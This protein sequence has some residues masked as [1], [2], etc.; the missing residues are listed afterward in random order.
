MLTVSVVI[1]C[2]NEEKTIYP[3]LESISQQTFPINDLEVIIADGLS[4]DG[5]RAEINRFSAVHPNLAVRIV[6]NT[7]K[8]IPSGLNIGIQAAKGEFIVR[9]D[10][11]SVPASDYIEKCVTLLKQGI[12]DNVG[13]VWLI[14]PGK[15]DWI[16]RSIAVAASHPIGVGDAGYR[17]S[18]KA[19]YVD[20]V[21]FGSYR[22]EFIVSL[23]AYN[24]TLLTNEDYELN[25][26]ILKAGGR[27]YLDPKIQ[28]VYFSRPTFSALAKQ[29]WRYGYWKA[30]MVRKYPGTVRW[31]QALPPLYL[32][33]LLGLLILSFV[34]S[35]FFWILF[36]V[37]VLYSSILMIA[38]LKIALS[39]QDGAFIMGVPLAIAIM[40][41][42]WGSGFLFS[43]LNL[44]HR[45]GEPGKESG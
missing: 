19:G 9:L 33:G 34:Y 18:T 5:T 36:G 6:D 8:T 45:K 23:G 35:F 38:S 29:Y 32:L 26:R 17:H 41:H 40:H 30:K 27:V 24:E 21:P 43:L 1:P 22:K 3:L 4:K 11:H 2:Y 13:G 10:A 15:N 31:R 16:G 37:V 20:T 12:A 7:K 25:V 14:R 42:S 39:K 28:C 44:N